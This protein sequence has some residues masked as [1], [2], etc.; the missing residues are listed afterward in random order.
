MQR[1]NAPWGFST[2]GP[3]RSPGKRSSKEPPPFAEPPMPPPLSVDHILEEVYYSYERTMKRAHVV[4]LH[5]RDYDGLISHMSRYYTP[6]MPK[7]SSAEVFKEGQIPSPNMTLPSLNT[8]ILNT[9]VG[10]VEVKSDVNCQ[11]GRVIVVN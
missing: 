4:L 8:T 2:S 3:Y 1:K 9:A 7:Y 6:R 11:P 10:S 5:P